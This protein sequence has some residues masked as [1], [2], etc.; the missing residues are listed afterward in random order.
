[1]TVPLFSIAEA[2]CKLFPPAP[3]QTAGGTSTGARPTGL[4]PSP[5][6][7]GK[8]IPGHHANRK[9]IVRVPAMTR[10]TWITPVYKRSRDRRGNPIQILLRAGHWRMVRVPASTRT[11][12]RRV[13]IKGHWKRG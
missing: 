6:D 8:W 4:T 9:V 12:T 7:R 3:A 1:M 11:E 10:K 13:W 5:Q 2:S